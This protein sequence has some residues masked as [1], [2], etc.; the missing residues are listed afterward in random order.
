MEKRSKKNIQKQGKHYSET[1]RHSIVQEK[2][3]NDW[4]KQYTYL[5]VYP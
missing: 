3:I 5:P 1:E 4:T 2:L